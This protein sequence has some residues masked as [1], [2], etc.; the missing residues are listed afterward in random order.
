METLW[1]NFD[2]EPIEI[3]EAVQILREQARSIQS[4]TKNK[5]R[6]TFSKMSYKAGPFSA[7]E[8]IGRVVNAMS[9]PV[10]EEI[11]DD[12]LQ[13]KTD[14][15][16][17]FSTTQY[18]F[19]IFNDEYR[20][21]LFVLNDSEMFP[22]TLEVDGGILEEI[23]YQNKSK[24]ESNEELKGILREIFSCGKLRKVVSKMLSK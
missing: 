14:A 3:N 5:I 15:N 13:E 8:Q 4:S 10:Y 2:E 19:E 9:S 11:L 24:I 23:S 7:V 22:I 12:E 1:P 16:T 6:A 18:K 20:F 21:R 17:L